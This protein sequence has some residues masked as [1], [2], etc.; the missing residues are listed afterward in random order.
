[1]DG[2]RTLAE[3]L[4]GAES[5]DTWFGYPAQKHA[6]HLFQACTL[7]GDSRAAYRAQD[8]GLA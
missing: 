3:Q 6:M 8:D 1:M 5:A 4:D 7:I 2:V